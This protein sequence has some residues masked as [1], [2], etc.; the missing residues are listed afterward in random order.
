[1]FYTTQLDRLLVL[2]RLSTT[3][4]G[5]LCL[6]WTFSSYFEDFIRTPGLRFNS[7]DFQDCNR[8]PPGFEIPK[9]RRFPLV[10]RP[11]SALSALASFCL[12]PR[13]SSS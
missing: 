12:A 8:T 2:D 10:F 5:I 7:W 4:A 6:L 1:M 11:V 3:I 13:R 9:I